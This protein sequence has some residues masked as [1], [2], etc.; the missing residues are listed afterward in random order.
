MI[1]TRY[2]QFIYLFRHRKVADTDWQQS[3]MRRW[4]VILRNDVDI[5]DAKFFVGHS[6]SYNTYKYKAVQSC[7]R[8]T[9]CHM[10]NVELGMY[11][12][13]SRKDQLNCA[14]AGGDMWIVLYYLVLIINN[15]TSILLDTC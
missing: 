15:L 9:S 7:D 13:I 14:R 12:N 2:V 6:F 5:E 8:H 4:N 10:S 11:K 1:L 3:A